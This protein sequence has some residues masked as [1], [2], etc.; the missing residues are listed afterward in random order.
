MAA[1]L[2]PTGQTSARCGIIA[3]VDL[4]LSCLHDLSALGHGGLVALVLAMAVAGLA[5]GFAHCAMMC[6]P[7][8]LAQVAAGADRSHSGGTLRRLSGAALLPYHLGRLVGYALLGAAAGALSGL[9]SGISGVRAVLALPLMLAA[10]A[11]LAMAAERIGGAPL[12]LRL[13]LAAPAAR[14]P[15]LLH[16][17][18]GRL[19]D[20]PAG[21][22]GVL[23]GLL[24]SGLPCGLLYGAL[25]GA[26]ASGSALAGA[27]SM[28]GFVIGTVPALVMVALAGRLALRRADPWL[29]PAGT[30]L[31]L[32]NGV[33]LA[34]LAVR[35]LGAA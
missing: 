29:R 7:F 5:G 31:L 33:L 34:A 35:Q 15:L 6:A 9:A 14:L 4:V 12:P 18:I 22:R 21:G 19:L 28:A 2:H 10:L 23:L 27:L 13:R 8:V 24:L 11:C 32:A 17:R 30:A 25:A 3:R 16:R 1:S 26:A 20:D